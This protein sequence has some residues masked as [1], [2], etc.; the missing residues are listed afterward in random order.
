MAAKKKPAKEK[1][2]QTLY[3]V[4]SANTG[5]FKCGPYSKQTEAKRE[6]DRLNQEAI[7][8]LGPK[9]EEFPNGQPLGIN[10]GPILH[11]GSL[12]QYEIVTESG[13]VVW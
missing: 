9:T 8:G 3:V 4:R 2:P 1:E 5:A 13:V 6:R 11:E 12:Q 10:G 7:T